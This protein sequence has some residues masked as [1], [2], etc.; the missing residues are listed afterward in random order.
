M[1]ATAKKRQYERTKPAQYT[2][3]LGNVW[4]TQRDDERL[5]ERCRSLSLGR[6]DEVRAALSGYLDAREHETA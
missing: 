3:R 4:I 5:R 1:S 6:A 2:A